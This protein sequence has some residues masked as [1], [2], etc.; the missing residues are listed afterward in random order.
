LY[1]TN[2]DCHPGEF[3]GQWVDFDTVQDLWTDLRQ[4]RLQPHGLTVSVGHQLE[5]YAR[6][7]VMTV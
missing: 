5:S 2:P 6:N 7:W 4:T 1:V 3:G